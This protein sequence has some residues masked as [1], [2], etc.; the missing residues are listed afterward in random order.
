MTTPKYA[1]FDVNT[2]EA[3]DQ[4]KR[5]FIFNQSNFDV[6]D[7]AWFEEEEVAPAKEYL[8]RSGRKLVSVLIP[9]ATVERFAKA[10]A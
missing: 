2:G 8:E 9:T 10:E 3:V 5:G 7:G 1:L 6:L 4:G